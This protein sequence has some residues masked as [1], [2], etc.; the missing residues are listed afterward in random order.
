MNT[1]II[2]IFVTFLVAVGGEFLKIGDTKP[3]KVDVRIIAATNRNFEQEIKGGHFRA[4]LYYRISVFEITLPT[5]RERV[6]DIALL[7]ERF[8]KQFALEQGNTVKAIAP[9]AIDAM[10]RYAWPGNIRELRNAMERAIILCTTSTIQVSDLPYEVQQQDKPIQEGASTLDL[11]SVEKEHIQKVLQ[12]TGGNKTK[13]A[14]LLG[15]ALTT[16]YRK[17][18]EYNIN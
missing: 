1:E 11:A 14:E 7:A 16:L 17:M 4:D 15:I 5:L 3:T 13:T 18:A 6:E 9:D 8:R 12:H 2:G 10:K